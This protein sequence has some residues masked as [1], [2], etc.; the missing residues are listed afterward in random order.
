MATPDPGGEGRQGLGNPVGS[1]ALGG[2]EMPDLPPRAVVMLDDR[3][4]NVGGDL[5]PHVRLVLLRC[6]R[7]CGNDHSIHCLEH[8]IGRAWLPSSTRGR[9]RGGVRRA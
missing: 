9:G 3:A 5:V 8:P 6:V 2:R 7:V 1:V 4:P